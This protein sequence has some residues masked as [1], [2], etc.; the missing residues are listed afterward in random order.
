MFTAYL[1]YDK[2]D[3]HP[4]SRELFG[5]FMH[6]VGGQARQFEKG[7]INGEHRGETGP[8]VDWTRKRAYGYRLG[9]LAD[10]RKGFEKATGLKIGWDDAELELESGRVFGDDE[11]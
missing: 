8:V 2:R 9:T 3:R 5:A 4:L 11:R 7:V 6:R 10:A 1:D